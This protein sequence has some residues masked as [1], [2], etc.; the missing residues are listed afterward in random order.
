MSVTIGRPAVDDILHRV[1]K[2]V[3]TDHAGGVGVGEVQEVLVDGG[4]AAHQAS[5]GVPTRNASADADARVHRLRAA[6]V[7][8]VA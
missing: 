8:G 4:L 2:L 5:A 6:E 3:E 7:A 1:E